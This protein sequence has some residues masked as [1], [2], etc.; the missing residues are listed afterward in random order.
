MDII[1]CKVCRKIFSPVGRQLVCKDCLK[2][3]EEEFQKV[4]DY[5]KENKGADIS[6]VSSETGVPVK[7]ILKYLKEGKVEVS[8]TNNSILK[9]EKCGKSIRSGR[10]CEQCKSNV[11]SDINNMVQ[12]TKEENMK[13]N[14]IRMNTKQYTTREK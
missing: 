4:R 8:D 6:L 5:L 12:K 3:E 2:A 11:I 9:C 13:K 14:S 1:N 10:F 7:K